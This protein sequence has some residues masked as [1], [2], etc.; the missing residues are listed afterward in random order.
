MPA[1]LPC[2]EARQARSCSVFCRPQQRVA[3]TQKY[4]EPLK[5]FKQKHDAVRLMF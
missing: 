5:D 1:P 2:D 4:Q 3:F